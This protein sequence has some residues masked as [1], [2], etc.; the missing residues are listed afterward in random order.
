MLSR[1]VDH[2][3]MRVTRTQPRVILAEPPLEAEH[4]RQILAGRARIAPIERAR[5][6]WRE[7]RQTAAGQRVEPAQDLLRGHERAQVVPVTVGAMV[8]PRVTLGI[9]QRRSQVEHGHRR[10]RAQVGHELIGA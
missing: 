6:G 3:G 9:E 4:A 1:R 5:G 10:V 8:D 2:A 7:R